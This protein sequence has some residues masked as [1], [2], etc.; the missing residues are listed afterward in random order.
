VKSYTFTLTSAQTLGTP[1]LLDNYLF[2]GPV[3]GSNINFPVTASGGQFLDT[4]YLITEDCG[5]FFPYG[6]IF[7]TVVHSATSVNLKG[8]HTIIFS[9][10]GL[11]TQY[12]AVLKI[13][14]DF[15]DGEV[16]NVER[17]IAPGLFGGSDSVGNPASN[18]VPH[19]YWP[20]NNIATTYTPSITVVNGNLS[21]DIYNLQFTIVP[22][23]I[24]EFNK[25]H[26]INTAQHTQSLDE[27][28]GVFE[29]D[30]PNYTTNARYFSAG[31]TAYNELLADKYINFNDI[32][33]LV[34]NLDASDVLTLTRDSRNKVY[35]WADKSD[36]HNDFEQVL[37]ASTPQFIYNTQS[38]AN[39]KAVRF[40]SN[41][42]TAANLTCNN[43]TA[44]DNITGGY[45][46]FFVARTNDINGIVFNGGNLTP[47][48][49]N[50]AFGFTSRNG[51]N[52]IQ[53]ISGIKIQ[54]IS[55]ILPSYSL[56]TITTY[57]ATNLLF[58]ADKQNIKYNNLKLSY[59]TLSTAASVRLPA[60]ATSTFNF[61]PLTDTEVSQVLIYNR[62]LSTE[63]YTYVKNTLVNKWGIT[64]QGD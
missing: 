1:E 34:L 33:G 9:P 31:T 15:G 4:S 10:S 57:N 20:K 12:Y 7:Q 17:D 25:M 42:T 36:Y 52:I 30:G 16:Y 49:P 28:L 38:R 32:P 40:T 18:G 37:P 54:D 60:S 43:L 55:L 58:T 63:E 61:V 59:G 64:L 47:T 5:L 35:K 39:R 21:L 50:L 56:Y 24:F 6:Y 26:L 53:G 27:T 51:V 2:T 41:S 8:P 48:Q 62:V 29:I 3:Y 22:S 11:D 46:S 44:F 14:Y 23:S 45:T 13:I 19:T